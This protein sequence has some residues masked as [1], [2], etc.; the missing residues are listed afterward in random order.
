MHHVG[1]LTVTKSSDPASGSEV[2]PG[3]T[4]TYTLT[5]ANGSP[6]SAGAAMPVDYT[7]HLARVLDDATWQGT[8]TTSAGLTAEL[9]GDTLVVTGN[10]APGGTAT[11]SYAVVVKGY[12]DQGDHDLLNVVAPT[13]LDPVCVPGSQL[14]TE[15][16]VPPVTPP[17][18]TDPPVTPT[19][20][21]TVPGTPS[22]PP[23]P[24][25][26]PATPTGP[27]T[28][29]QTGTTVTPALVVGALALLTAGGVLLLVG[30]RRQH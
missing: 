13:G 28:L 21:P 26:P 12:P 17:E 6:N 22:A 2:A 25:V 19:P 10:V 3:D 15:H 7:D 27:G 14:C 24:T 23:S 11:V 4:I 30:R 1:R 20:T 8:P 29:P 9:R 16:T 18:P 5:F